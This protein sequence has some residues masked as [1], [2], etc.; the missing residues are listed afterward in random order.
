MTHS[1][2]QQDNSLNLELGISY[3]G[4]NRRKYTFKNHKNKTMQKTR[5][6]IISDNE[7][8]IWNDE[9][10]KFQRVRQEP[11]KIKYAIPLED[12]QAMLPRINNQRLDDMEDE[13]YIIELEQDEKPTSN[14]HPL[15]ASLLAPYGIK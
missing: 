12:A 11:D 14:M 4:T 6:A 13:A 7:G 8:N 10:K 15:F 1:I 3:K 9:Q 2:H 5:T